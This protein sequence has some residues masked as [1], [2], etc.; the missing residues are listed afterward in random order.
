MQASLTDGDRMLHEANAYHYEIVPRARG[1][2]AKITQEA[3]GY[4]QEVVAR[5]RGEADRFNQV[6][7]EYKKN[8]EVSRKRLYLDTMEHVLSHVHKT[9]I[10]PKAAPGLVPYF[11]L[12]PGVKADKKQG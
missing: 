7:T 10:D 12:Q 2:S 8:P 11:H 6:Y 9:I 4:M 1:E 5:A 3:E